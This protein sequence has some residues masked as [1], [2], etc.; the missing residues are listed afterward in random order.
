MLVDYNGKTLRLP[1]FLIVGAAKSG[2]TS[3][4]YYLKQHPRIFMPIKKE[5]YFFSYVGMP[6]DRIPRW[7]IEEF[8]MPLTAVDYA[9]CFNG[10]RERQIAGE[11]C[12]T[13]LYMPE[14]TIGNIKRFYGERYKEL[15]IIIILRNPVERAWSHYTMHLRNGIE[16]IRDFRKVVNPEVARKRLEDRWDSGFDYLGKGRYYGQVIAYIKEF[17]RIKVFLYEDLSNEPQKLVKNIFGFLGV[18]DRFI[19]DMKT[20]YNVSGESSSKVLDYLVAKNN[21]VKNLFKK[22]LPYELRRK[23]KFAVLDRILKKQLMPEDIKRE[24]QREY[25]DD[26][27]RLQSLLNRDLSA[28]LA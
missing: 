11:A 14:T 18:D 24:L 2:T 9:D 5:L 21:F 13:Y 15:K 23:V 26:I 12:Q 22:V 1:D 4:H 16:P 3:L 27:M 7:L 8:K 28:W 10:A 6:E 17:P 19:P 20:K 25:K